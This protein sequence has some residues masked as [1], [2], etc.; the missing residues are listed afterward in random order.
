[1]LTVLV[2]TI[3]LE[4]L[5]QTLEQLDVDRESFHQVVAN[6]AANTIKDHLIDLNTKRPNALGGKRSNFYSNASESVAFEANKDQ[7][8]VSITQQDYFVRYFYPERNPPLR[9]S[10]G[11]VPANAGNV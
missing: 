8:T 6:A 11:P 7:A 10:R 5:Q 4:A 3:G 2:N 9:Q 1:M